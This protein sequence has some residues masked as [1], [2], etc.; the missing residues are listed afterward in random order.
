MEAFTEYRGPAE[1]FHGRDE[2]INPFVRVLAHYRTKNRGTT[3]II[4][5]PPG[6]GK[7]ALLHELSE[8]AK[9]NG[10]T[11]KGN[12]NAPDFHDPA[13]MAAKL[14]V[15]HTPRKSRGW[16]LGGK[17]LGWRGKK[18]TQMQS[19][20]VDII[21]KAAP[22]EGLILVLD[23]AQ[24]L[25]KIEGRGDDEDMAMATLDM[26]HNGEIGAPVILLAGGLGTTDLAFESLGISRIE[27]SCRVRLG[28]L[29]PAST[30][31]VI[32]DHLLHRCGLDSPPQNWVE[33]LA[34]PT[35]GWPHH[36][37]CYVESAKEC[38]AASHHKPTSA[39]LQ[40]T[41][42]VGRLRKI[43]YY[44]VRAQGISKKQRRLIAE[45]FTDLPPGGTVD[46]E[47][48]IQVIE[49]HYSKKDAVD[50]FSRVLRKGILD[51]RGDGGFAVPIPSMQ[52]WLVDVYVRGRD[53][54]AKR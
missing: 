3:F 12:L 19:E 34:E 35:H 28:P 45:L 17:W 33:A 10:Y 31:A 37:M 50:V 15:P 36:I 51:E 2:V 4:K 23:E 43:H 39:A 42:E 48:V 8:H 7:T 18:E 46:K 26:I 29:D 41:L 20:V 9:M 30:R 14:G 16:S 22:A 47:D 24:H 32:Y 38:L 11:V 13:R 25:A 44:E 49:E 54:D 21:K 53:L 52:G 6:S 27:E 1:F 40:H 5:G